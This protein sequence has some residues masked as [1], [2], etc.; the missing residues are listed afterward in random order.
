MTAQPET[1]QWIVG[2]WKFRDSVTWVA[3]EGVA[4]DLMLREQM[5]KEEKTRGTYHD[6]YI[7]KVSKN[8][9]GLGF[10]YE[11]SEKEVND[12]DGMENVQKAHLEEM[13]DMLKRKFG[14]DFVGWDIASP[15]RIIKRTSFSLGPSVLLS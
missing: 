5:E 9:V 10:V 8:Q 11:P 12:L 7:R 1:L 6:L 2:L 13:S 15:V 3:L 4:Y 14:N